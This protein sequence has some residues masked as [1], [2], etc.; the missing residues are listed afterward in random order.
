MKQSTAGSRTWAQKVA[1]ERSTL[2]AEVSLQQLV[3]IGLTVVAMVMLSVAGVAGGIYYW[4]HSDPYVQKVLAI[5]GESSR[6]N[7]I[8]QLN[9]AGCHGM[10][11][12]GK[13]GPSLQGIGERRSRWGL[14][15]QITS[16]QTPPMPKFQA[17]P[18]E[19]ADL[20]SY[21]KTL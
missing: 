12:D 11:A 2:G 4:H 17:S 20:L 7:S 9:C 13:V 15:Q 8:F 21:L 5:R 1:E 14:I 19:M 6:G 18:K 10:K 3:L 16:G